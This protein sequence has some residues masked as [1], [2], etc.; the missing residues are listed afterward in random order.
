MEDSIVILATRL[1]G[2][3]S[4]LRSLIIVFTSLVPVSAEQV[5]EV[6]GKGRSEDDQLE[7]TYSKHGWP[8]AT[9][10][11][12]ENLDNNYL[13][14][15]DA[16]EI[17]YNPASLRN[18]KIPQEDIGE[19]QLKK[20]EAEILPEQG[21]TPFVSSPTD[22][23][24]FLEE[25]Q[26]DRKERSALIPD[27]PLQ[28]VHEAFSSL[29]ENLYD[30]TGIRIGL[31]INHVSQ[32]LSVNQ[33]SLDSALLE[34]FYR[35]QIGNQPFGG[36]TT[37]LDLIV[38]WEVINKGKPNVGK[39]YAHL[40]GRWDY[41]T[42]G[43]QNLGF[44]TLKSAQGTANAFSG[45][46]PT[47]LLRNLYWQH[48]SAEAGW[49]YRIGRITTDSILATSKYL[50]P[51]TTFLSNAGTGLFSSGYPDT[52]YGAMGAIKLSDRLAV[53]GLVADTYGNRFTDGD[54]SKKTFYTAGEILFKQWP[55]TENA[56]YSK[57]TFWNTPGGIPINAATGKKGWGMTVKLEQELTSDGRVVGIFR[58]GRSFDG[59]A[60]WDQQVGT[61]VV[62]NN[63][64]LLRILRDDALGVGFNWVKVN[65]ETRDEYGIECFYR[66]PL[67]ENMDLTLAYQYTFQP[68]NAVTPVLAQSLLD[69][70]SAFS[71]RLRS[72][73]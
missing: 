35:N 23:S 21:V 27:Y 43:P 51:V 1:R 57:I 60:I 58:W 37:D 34:A 69:G 65:D 19:V 10:T 67:F 15:G 45:Y 31:N 46:D 71:L 17:Q 64:R 30:A 54:I 56:G 40:E 63:P 53:L 70:G 36:S 22:P 4:F 73:F 48:G 59:A 50:S 20:S 24:Y 7:I 66:F 47:F 26:Q 38:S 9:S 68:A 62:Y 39:I 11:E 13:L 8:Y 44:L 72:T 18:N 2:K 6:S 32:S 3:A 14:A 25:I 49:V 12:P 41:G 16:S 29:K 55:L 28:E 33:A 42:R 5:V 52:G 61:H